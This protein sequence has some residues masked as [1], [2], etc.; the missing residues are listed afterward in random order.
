M[1]APSLPPLPPIFSPLPF[2]VRRRVKASRKSDLRF[3]L[4]VDA[5]LSSR[6]IGSSSSRCISPRVPPHHQV[7]PTQSASRWS[8]SPS[9]SLRTTL[10]RIVAET[11]STA[12]GSTSLF[13]ISVKSQLMPCVPLI[14]SQICSKKLSPYTTS[15][16]MRVFNPVD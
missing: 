5:R 7:G 14:S 10:A 12:A 16:Y 6:D 2:P 15:K 3:F 11:A 9:S 1:P 8:L 13:A 4:G